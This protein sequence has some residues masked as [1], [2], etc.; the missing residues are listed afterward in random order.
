LILAALCVGL[1]AWSE[2]SHVESKLPYYNEKVAAAK[3]MD[4]ALR[5][6]QDATMEK[7]DFTNEAY[8]DP[9]LTAII[10]QQFSLITTDF[11]VFETK[12]IGANPNFA[13]AVVDLLKQADVQS[14][15]FV[16]VG[17]TGSQPGANIAVL[18]ACEALG[19]IPVTITAI[20]SSWWGA[21]D[22]EMTWPDMERVLDEQGIV[23]SRAIAASMGGAG[24]KAFG[25]SKIGQD[26][27]R[28]AAERNHLP[29][30]LEENLHTSVTRRME[31]YGAAAKGHAYKA[32]VTVGQGEADLGHSANAGLIGW[33]YQSKL[34]AKNYPARGVAHLFNDQNV[35]VINLSDVAAV[36]REYGLGGPQIPLPEVGEGDAYITERYDL[37]VAGISALIALALILILVR[38]DAK[39]F[40]L[41]EAGVDPDTLM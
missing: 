13:A 23:H 26:L 32:F 2:R 22:P 28:T 30:V 33:G 37:R 7:G 14:G 34:P 6:L 35:P 21:N 31:L 24:D 16:A 1:Y 27:I 5:T 8:P 20:G 9:R 15:D 4:H 10:G 25:L 39:L 40:R 36:S 3:L 18:C 11:D 12:L 29:L 41:K 38:L 19:A 17:C